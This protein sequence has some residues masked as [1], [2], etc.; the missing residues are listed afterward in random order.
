MLQLHH[1]V[2]GN[3][4]ESAGDKAPLVLIHGLFGSM[5]N[6]GGIARLL[7]D[8]FV[9]HSLDMRNHGRSPHAQ[10]MDYSLMAADVI[11]YMDNAGIEKAHLL[12]HSMGG[13]TAMQ[14]ALEYPQRVEK[15]IVADIAPVAYPPHHKDILAGLTALDPASLS[16]RQEADELVKPYVPELPVR[17]FLLKNLQKGV[18]G[19]FSWRMNLP[20]IQQNYMNIMAGQDAQQPFPGPVLFVKGGNSDY[21]QPKHRE[22][23]ARLFPAAGLRVI[24]HTGHWLHAEKP[25]LFARVAERFL[26]NE[27]SE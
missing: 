4:Q 20:A 1:R 5:E 11:R 9:I 2:Q 21:I 23:I 6:L 7:A 25:E 8:N 22:H 17:Q 3:T 14:I 24:P 16:S 15:L 18:D 13:K 19:R 10:M 12:G 27:D 26:M